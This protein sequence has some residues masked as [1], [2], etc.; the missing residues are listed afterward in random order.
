MY[1]SSYDAQAFPAGGYGSKGNRDLPASLAFD[2]PY[3]SK[4]PIMASNVDYP[5][6]I[7]KPD[8]P[9]MAMPVAR[10]YPVSYPSDLG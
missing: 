5:A 1:D 9:D 7:D 8:R 10:A 3:E 6:G 2:S 4:P